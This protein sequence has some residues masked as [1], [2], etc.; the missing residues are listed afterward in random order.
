MWSPK[1]DAFEKDNRLI[2]RVDLPGV[3]T[4]RKVPIQEA[5]AVKTAA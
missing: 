3:K 4:G 5:A 1:V 2:T